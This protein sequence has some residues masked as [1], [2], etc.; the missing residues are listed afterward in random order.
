MRYI[1]ETGC[2]GATL[3]AFDPE[4]LPDDADALL[5]DD[6]MGYMERW[7]SEGRFWVGGTGSDGSFVFHVHVDEPLPEAEAG[8]SRELEAKFERF[9]C[10]SGE[11]WFCGAEYAARDPN[12]GSEGTPDGGLDNYPSQGGHITLAPGSYGVRIYRVERPEPSDLEALKEIG[13]IGKNARPADLLVIAS[14][15]FWLLGALATFG[16]AIMLIIS[17]PLKFYQWV[18]DNPLFHKGWHAFPVAIAFLV[19]GLAS[20]GLGRWCDLRYRRSAGAKAD[21][22]ARLARADYVVEISSLHS[23]Q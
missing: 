22:A 18:T 13:K 19:G 10:P 3:C 15:V 20:I 6:P 16:A 17:L 23:T 2:D 12:A 4:A 7:Q 9:A 21:N 14:M 8:T 5:L 1:I 11:L